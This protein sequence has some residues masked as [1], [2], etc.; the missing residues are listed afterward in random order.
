[1]ARWFIL[2][3]IYLTLR[4]LMRAHMAHGELLNIY[5]SPP[6]PFI[7]YPFEFILL[8]SKYPLSQKPACGASSWFLYFFLRETVDDETAHDGEHHNPIL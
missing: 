2:I 1:M 5:L 3:Y 7:L 6:S 8:K 4:S